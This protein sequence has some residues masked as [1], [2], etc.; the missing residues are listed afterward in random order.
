[1]INLVCSRRIH[2]LQLSSFVMDN[3]N[4]FLMVKDF[5]RGR[6]ALYNEGRLEPAGSLSGGVVAGLPALEEQPSVVELAHS[7][8]L[9]MRAQMP[10]L[11]PMPEQVVR[12]E[13]V[14]LPRPKLMPEPVVRMVPVPMPRPLPVLVKVRR[15]R[16]NFFLSFYLCYG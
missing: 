14:P 13:P 8:L 15:P 16:R 11:V 6:Y 7:P 4:R 10:V 1:M 3:K 5:A 9:P 2:Q 12:V